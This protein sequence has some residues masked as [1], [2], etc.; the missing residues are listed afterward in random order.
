MRLLC[1]FAAEEKTLYLSLE[2][3]IGNI[4]LKEALQRNGL[5]TSKKLLIAFD[6][7]EELTARLRKDRSP[8]VILIDT[9]QYWGITYDEY[10]ALVNEFKTRL[11]VFMSHVDAGG[12]VPDGSTAQR[13]KRDS[14]MRLWIEGY[15]AFNR[16]RTWGRTNEYIIWSQGADTYWGK[17][18]E[19]GEKDEQGTENTMAQ[20][21]AHDGM[22]PDVE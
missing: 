11:F 20:E 22:G 17:K 21:D 7:I 5:S 14:D 6:S 12:R 19:G 3:G 8:R 9:V 10:R 16:G 13:I 2:E 1:L 18:N 4:H 15:K